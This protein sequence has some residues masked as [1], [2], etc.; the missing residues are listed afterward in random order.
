MLG[1]FCDAAPRGSGV[2]RSYLTMSDSPNAMKRASPALGKKTPST[3]SQS[4]RHPPPPSQE[5]KTPCMQ[6]VGDRLRQQGFSEKATEVTLESWRPDTKKVYASYIAEWRRTVFDIFLP[7]FSPAHTH[8]PIHPIDKNKIEDKAAL[9]TFDATPGLSTNRH[10]NPFV[11]R[12]IES[13]QY[14]AGDEDNDHV[15]HEE[16]DGGDDGTSNALSD[17]FNSNASSPLP[18]LKFCTPNSFSVLLIHDYDAD[19]ETEA[20]DD[21]QIYGIQPRYVNAVTAVS[22]M[23]QKKKGKT[24]RMVENTDRR[25]DHMPMQ[26]TIPSTSR[27]VIDA[28]SSTLSKSCQSNVSSDNLNNLLPSDDQETEC[29]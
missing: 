7:T 18:Y 25:P 13:H 20:S 15:D 3:P 11:P 9:D 16:Y 2:R 12:H 26:S 27:S 21:G 10:E 19:T 8:H 22:V 28:S 1:R 14:G 4:S 5:T 6:G 23:S 24:K 17:H 29:Y